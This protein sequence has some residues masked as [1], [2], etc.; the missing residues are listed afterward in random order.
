MIT[1]AAYTNGFADGWRCA[2][3]LMSTGN[4]FEEIAAILEPESVAR[5]PY[6]CEKFER[7]M[8]SQ[9]DRLRR[10]PWN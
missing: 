5:N 1:D 2:L 10:T 6:V 4:T 8:K 9:V 7:E 3:G